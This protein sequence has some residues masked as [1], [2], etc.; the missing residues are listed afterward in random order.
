MVYFNDRIRDL[1]RGYIGERA[2]GPL[3]ES[4]HG[5]RLSSRQVARRLWYWLARAGCRRA[6]CHSLRHARGQR[7]YEQTGDPYM[8]MAALGHRSIA[9]SLAYVRVDERRVRAMLEA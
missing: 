4:R 5:L 9:S 2:T 6:S 8:V 7:V 1:L 3:W